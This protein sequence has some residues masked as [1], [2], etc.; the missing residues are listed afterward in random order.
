MS[1]KSQQHS[2]PPAQTNQTPFE[3]FTNALSKVVAV[4]KSAIPALSKKP[5][6]K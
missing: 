2:T 5:K 6:K 3:R 4:P 1:G